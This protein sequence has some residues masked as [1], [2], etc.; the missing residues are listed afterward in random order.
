MEIDVQYINNGIN[1]DKFKYFFL[2]KSKDQ[3][4][5]AEML[6]IYKREEGPKELFNINLKFSQNYFF[7]LHPSRFYI[8]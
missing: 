3:D 8:C 1:M 5:D 6:F 7:S 4:I 2:A